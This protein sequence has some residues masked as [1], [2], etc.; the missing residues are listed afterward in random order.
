[1]SQDFY[2]FVEN[3]D[4]NSP[5]PSVVRHP[6]RIAVYDD[7]SAAPRVVVIEPADVRAYLEEITLQVSQLAQAQG[8]SIPFMVI[9]EI[10]ENFIHAYFMEPTI[11]IL[12]HGNTIRF[13]DQGPGIR[14]KQRALQ[15]GT[16]SATEEM[17]RYIRGVGS[18]L[19]YA[20]QY[21]LDKG[22]RLEI[23]DNIAGGT[24][25]TI[26]LPGAPDPM[27][28]QDVNAPQQMPTPAGQQP[29]V[30]QQPYTQPY[31]QQYPQAYP[32][33]Y[34]QPMPGQVPYGQQSYGQ[35]PYGQQ[36]YPMQ[37]Q[38]AYPQQEG[39]PSRQGFPTNQPAWP[40]QQGWPAQPAPQQPA[41]QLISLS[42]RGRAI[43]DYLAAHDS[44]GPSDL[45]REY[46]ESQPTWTRELQ[47][48]EEQGL[49][50]KD[51]QKRRLTTLGR[52]IIQS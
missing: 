33:P 13:S 29:W 51:G 24:I 30:P 41:S 7:A 17:R 42:V 2:P 52:T 14:E 27:Q 35:S 49:I 47:A 1:M 21:M 23:E 6:A 40:E 43:M 38:Q 25:V 20:Q 26:S 39:W 31:P 12:D 16:T 46:G 10:V 36:A 5:E 18:G 15:Y 11:S 34:Q 37:P 22:G 3:A 44:V 4:G 50:R 28:G 32:Q 48:L 19:P 9:R 8:G 45:A